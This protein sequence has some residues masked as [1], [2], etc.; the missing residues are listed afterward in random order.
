VEKNGDIS[1]QTP[2]PKRDDEKQGVDKTAK[3]A[4]RTKEEA[5]RMEDGPMS[6]VSKAVSE[7]S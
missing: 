5:D 7:D 3:V 1:S 6:R 2:K 4:P